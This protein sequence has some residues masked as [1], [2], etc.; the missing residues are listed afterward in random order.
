M[1]LPFFTVGH[2]TRP[3]PAF[4]DLL[5]AGG[6]EL[7]IDIRTAPR[8]RTKEVLRNDLTPLA[9]IISPCD[10]RRMSGNAI[11]LLAQS[12]FFQRYEK[13]LA[14]KIARMVRD[15]LRDDPDLD[16][17]TIQGDVLAACQLEPLEIGELHSVSLETAQREYLNVY[18]VR[19]SAYHF[20]AVVRYS[21]SSV[22]WSARPN[23]DFNWR[24]GG[25]VLSNTVRIRGVYDDKNWGEIENWVNEGLGEAREAVN[26]F[27][28]NVVMFNLRLAEALPPAVETLVAR[29]KNARESDAEE[30]E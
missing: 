30:I 17:E 15:L 9:S 5:R 12:K 27:G 7:V 18:G 20:E 23:T 28:P 25:V 16:A 11:A 21:G 4:V 14:K 22:L 24:W 1:S 8:S 29:F 10:S 13:R 26:A 6:V 2:S 19:L 3:I